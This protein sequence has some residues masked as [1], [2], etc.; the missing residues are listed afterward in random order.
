MYMMLL[1]DEGKNL[2]R[3]HHVPVPLGRTI[4]RTDQLVGISPPVMIKALVPTGGRG[5]AGG[6]VL[7]SDAD[8]IEREVRRVLQMTISGYAVRSVLV[9]EALTISREMYLGILID[10]SLGIPAILVSDQGGM[11][12]E[13]LPEGTVRKVPVHPFLGIGAHQVREV[14][15]AL[16]MGGQENAVQGLLTH[17]W[18]L[19]VAK[20][21]ELVEINPLVLTQGGELMAVDSKIMINDD[22]LFRHPE[23]AAH[24]EGE[25][26]LESAARDN[27][28]A[29]VRLDG[30]IGV[31][32]NGA[33][34]TM[35]TLDEL[36]LS[37]RAAGAFMDLG[38]TDDPARVE[39]AFDIMVRSGPKVI[40]IN[41][42]GGIT[43]CDTVAEGV[44]RALDRQA[45]KTPVVAR[46]RG[47]N[48]A[49]AREMLISKGIAAHMSLEDAVRD[50]VRL[51]GGA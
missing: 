1:E 24:R 12:V 44:L 9:E 4:T 37:G 27:G 43:R 50:V 5:K 17:L 10:R 49:K 14:A 6:V 45:G 33:G 7:A 42:F 18:E 38:G 30:D 31:I 23:L 20:D 48:E 16:G 35:A 13:S 36:A 3:D 19:F 47:V 32:A 34:L 25:D 29:F 8:G 41:I 28:I 40:L 26:A 21:C 39:T 15:A 46:I 11:E 22:S 2:L 51:G